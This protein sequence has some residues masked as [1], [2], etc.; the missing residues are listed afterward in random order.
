MPTE[1]E[2]AINSNIKAGGNNPLFLIAGPCVIENEKHTLYLAEE[3]KNICDDLNMPFI[4]KASYDKA[5]RSSIK[6]YRG[7]GLETGL[8]I[9]SLVKKNTGV[10]VLSDARQR[11]RGIPGVPL[12]P[13]SQRHDR[14]A[15][16][17]LP[18]AG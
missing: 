15:L 17:A 9:L 18:E 1:R 8:E 4:F 11:G 3:I 6:S 14:G 10:P 16:G 5:N 13:G 2:I 12:C 7:P